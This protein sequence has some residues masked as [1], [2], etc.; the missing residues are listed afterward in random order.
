MGM[1]H[2]DAGS[3]IESNITAEPGRVSL[4]D[5]ICCVMLILSSDEITTPPRIMVSYIP[6]CVIVRMGTPSKNTVLLS[7]AETILMTL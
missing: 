1:T 3:D 6:P 4:L 5:T 7:A 2:N